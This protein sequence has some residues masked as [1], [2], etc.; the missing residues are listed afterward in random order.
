MTA[1][2][3]SIRENSEFDDLCDRVLTTGQPIELKRTHG[4]SVSLIATEELN[5]LLETIHLLQSPKN[6]IR[7]LTALERAKTQKLESQP[8]DT[9]YQIAHLSPVEIAYVESDILPS[10]QGD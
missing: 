1:N 10:P 3:Y 7:L 6:A 8:I 9:L 4:E 5:R 2:L